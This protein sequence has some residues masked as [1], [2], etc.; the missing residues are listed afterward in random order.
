MTIYIYI[1]IYYYILYLSVLYRK[2]MCLTH[3]TSKAVKP[4]KQH[5]N[6]MGRRPFGQSVQLMQNVAKHHVEATF[7]SAI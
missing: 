6:C 5:V 1:I 4:L 7:S 3:R 2:N